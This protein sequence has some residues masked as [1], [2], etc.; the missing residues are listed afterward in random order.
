MMMRLLKRE[1]SLVLRH[2][3]SSTKPDGTAFD[4]DE[5]AG[6]DLAFGYDVGSGEVVGQCRLCSEGD[7]DSADAES[8]KQ[9]ADFDLEYSQPPEDGEGVHQGWATSS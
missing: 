5:I 9:R 2:E 7:G 8:G 3:M 6:F 1:R 4:L